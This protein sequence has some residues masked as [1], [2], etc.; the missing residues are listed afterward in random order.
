MIRKE[1]RD[2][3]EINLLEQDIRCCDEILIEK[4]NGRWLADFEFECWFDVDAYFGINTRDDEEVYVNFYV[5]YIYD[6]KDLEAK[7]ELLY[8]DD[9][10][11]VDWELTEDE[12]VFL[13]KKM[14]EYAG[15]S[16]IELFSTCDEFRE[17]ILGT[18]ENWDSIENLMDDELREEL[19]SELYPCTQKEFLDEYCKRH[20]EKFNEEFAFN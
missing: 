9:H 6:T 17:D 18:V 14:E 7:Y 20:K 3:R 19:H 4:I 15:M 8:E 2:M 1:I 11:C 16:L 5:D 10:F 12:K 13:K